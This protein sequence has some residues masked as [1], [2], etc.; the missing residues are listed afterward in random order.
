MLFTIGAKR[1]KP[2][3]RDLRAKNLGFRLFCIG[4]LFCCSLPQAMGQLTAR[5]ADGKTATTYTN[6]SGNRDTIFVFNQTPQAKPGNLTL[7]QPTTSTFNWY[8]YDETNKKF[9]DSPFYTESGTFTTQTGLQQGGY[10]VTVLPA[11]TAYIAWI[12][13]NP[14][15][16]FKLYKDANGE[17]MRNYKFC[18]HTD[19]RLDPETPTSQS[20]FTYYNPNNT[21]QTPLVLDN[22]I[23][24]TMRPGSASGSIVPLNTQGEKQ[25]LRDNNPPHENMRY[26]FRAYDMFGVERE[27]NIMY[28]TIIPYVTLH[29]PVL[30][31][32]DP[33]SAP[34]PVKFSC[35]P[36]RIDVQNSE[37]I[38]RFGTG[39]SVVY[40]AENVPP[41]T[42]KYTYYTPKS[43]GYQVTV[44]V[45]GEWGWGCTY[46]TPPVKIT[47]DDP[48]L[49]VANVF[50]PNGDNMN[51]YFKPLTVSLRQFEISIYTRT[52]KRIYHYR[53]N[54]LRSWKGWDGRI[55]N[56][57]RN[58]AE[59]V[60][61]YVVN[62]IGWDEPPT[63]YNDKSR[64]S[65]QPQTFGGS[66]HLYR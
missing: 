21:P 37:Y 44:R 61:F 28:Q 41:D 12:Y 47:V 19:F 36:N 15:F 42:V 40:N 49:E 4:V 20:S 5:N 25:Y 10:K 55:E 38:W 59:G 11:D 26:Y 33:A 62:G 39:D 18:T 2:V 45:V 1:E 6:A 32:V 64:K 3:Y 24:F 13:L 7:Q 57:G 31:D 30:P 8:Q 53:G 65:A 9:E 17:L 54:D 29:T 58:A 43:S 34:V 35:Q 51:D 23:T 56:S 16:N 50:T 22:K 46:I 48:Q 63:V 14:G 52:G 66:F 27:D 60:Y